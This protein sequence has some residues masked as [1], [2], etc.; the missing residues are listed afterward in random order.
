LLA[1]LAVVTLIVQ[2]IVERKTGKAAIAGEE[3]EPAP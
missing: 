1:L 3:G 2:M